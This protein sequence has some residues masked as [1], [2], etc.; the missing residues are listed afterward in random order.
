MQFFRGLVQLCRLLVGS[1]F[2]VSGLIK[3]NDALGFMYKLEEYFEPG[4]LNLPGL[5][6]YALSLSVIICIGEILLGVAMVIG[7]LPKLTAALTGILMAFF[8]WLTWYTANCD[9]FATKMIVDA[10][11][12]SV[13]IANQCVLACGCF[14]NAI[15]LTPYES[16]IKDVV[17]S[18]LTI[19][20]VWGA[21]KGWTQ[22]NTKR[23]GLVLISGSLVVIYA[24]GSGMLDWNFPVLFAAMAYA[25]AEG[26]KSRI[27]GVGR[28]WIMAMGVL[29]VCGAFQYHTLIHLP[30]KDYRPYAAGE[31]IFKNRKSAEELELEGPKYATEYT[32]KNIRTQEDTIILSTEW[33]KIYSEP[34][35]KE[36]YETVSFDGAEIQIA[37]GYE[38]RIMDFQI[39]D[40]DGE[41]LADDF[42]QMEGDLLIHVSK[43]LDTGARL[44]QDDLNALAKNAMANGWTMIGLTNAP[45]DQNEEYRAK[46]NAPYPFYTCD[47]TE[48]KIVVRANPGLVWIHNGVVQEKWSWHDVP[49]WDDLTGEP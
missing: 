12:A 49:T 11:G 35:F 36:G 40:V 14:G 19:P 30:V 4:A 22:L 27:S 45:A 33:I 16:F 29:I 18:I 34:W 43:D 46:V 17:L 1:L 44:G 2:I 21:F 28:E 3:S 37:E 31:S 15:P 9:P 39:V 32:F 48:L 13:E 20:I 41:D 7:A 25:V 38:P 42:L 5:E 8:T 10:T 26:L 24:F 47:Q 6:D 23:E